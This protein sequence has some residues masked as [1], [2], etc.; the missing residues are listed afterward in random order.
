MKAWALLLLAAA[1]PYYLFS[2]DEPARFRFADIAAQAGLAVPNTYGGKDRQ[3]SILESTGT[4]AAI[5]DYNGDGA[6]DIF[7]ANGTTTD[8]AA[9]PLSQLYRNDGKGR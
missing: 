2:G 1:I 4:G 9:P 3:S 6:N 5:F 8:A 7:I